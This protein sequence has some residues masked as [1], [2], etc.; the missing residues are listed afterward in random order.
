MRRSTL[1]K[2]A[3]ACAAIMLVTCLQAQQVRMCMFAV[4][5][6]H[7]WTFE[8]G[9]CQYGLRGDESSTLILFA[10]S[11]WT[12]PVPFYGVVGSIGAGCAALGA[13]GIWSWRKK[14]AKLERG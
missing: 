11:T 2:V 5:P 12:V 9:E 13:L 1:N 8:L 14:L 6:A 7:D 3:I 10:W 4:E